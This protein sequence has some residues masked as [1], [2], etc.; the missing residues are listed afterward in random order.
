VIVRQDSLA[1]K[2]AELKRLL[3]ISAKPK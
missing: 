2:I 3:D 1:A